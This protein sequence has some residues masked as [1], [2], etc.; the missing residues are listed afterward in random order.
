MFQYHPRA[1]TTH[2]IRREIHENKEGLTFRELAKKYNVSVPTVMKWRKRK[3][4]HDAPHGPNDIYKLT[5][6]T[7]LEEYVL[8]EIRK[9]ALLPLDDLLEVASQLDIKVSRSA[10]DRALR[11]N[12]L[13]NLRD[14]INSLDDATQEEIK[15][16]KDYKP[17]FLHIDIK[18]LPKIDGARQYLYVAI[19]RATRLVYASIM[20]DKSSQSAALFLEEVLD[21][22]PFQI[23]KILT[24]NGKEFTDRF[25]RGGKEASGGHVFDKKCENNGI[26]HRLTK[27]Y[28]PKTNGMV[29]RFNGKVQKDVLD[30]IKFKNFDELRDCIAQYWYNYNHYIKHSGINRMTPFEKLQEYYSAVESGK[31]NEIKFLK[32]LEEFVQFE[33]KIMH[34]YNMGHDTSLI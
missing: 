25:R 34:N 16:F 12:G 6:I 20:Q 7:Q 28:T 11:R 31:E 30:K 14:Y 33:N 2:E 27:P 8:C 22:F 15:K 26:E 3:D 13:S 10:L 32:T 5:G 29:E 21:F 1:K 19:D 17:G 24:D 9:S 18:Y 4:F 23:R